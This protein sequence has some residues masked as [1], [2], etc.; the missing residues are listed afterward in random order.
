MKSLGMRKKFSSARLFVVF[1]ERSGRVSKNALYTFPISPFFVDK[2]RLYFF[3]PVCFPALYFIFCELGIKNGYFVHFISELCSYPV[4]GFPPFWCDTA[5]FPHS[6]TAGWE[7]STFFN[8]CFYTSRFCIFCTG[9][10]QI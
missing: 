1:G 10:V 6:S 9:N 5:S 4:V 8:T 2:W 7:F 3:F